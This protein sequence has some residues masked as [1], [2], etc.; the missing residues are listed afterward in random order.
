MH[1]GLAIKLRARGY[2][3]LCFCLMGET[4]ETK[5]VLLLCQIEREREK[6]VQSKHAA[7][8]R[9]RHAED[10]GCA[11]HYF[12]SPQCAARWP[13]GCLLLSPLQIVH[14]RYIFCDLC[15]SFFCSKPRREILV[16]AYLY[17]CARVPLFSFPRTRAIILGIGISPAPDE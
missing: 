2:R 5:N 1:F 16:H 4:R 11:S 15:W 8:C 7:T 3:S 13:R 17:K 6:K 9:V 10:L 14:A 12:A